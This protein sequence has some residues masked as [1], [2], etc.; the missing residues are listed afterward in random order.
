MHIFSSL[1]SGN[2]LSQTE[3]T[4]PASHVLER[5]LRVLV[6]SRLPMSPHR[7]RAKCLPALEKPHRFTCSAGWR[8]PST[9]AMSRPFARTDVLVASRTA[10]NKNS[11][12]SYDDCQSALDKNS[13][14]HL[15]HECMC[16]SPTL[17]RHV[18]RT[19]LR[20]H[21]NIHAHAQGCT[22]CQ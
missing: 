21:V 4:S 9:P 17:E 2:Q 16:P 14:D 6:S 20:T 5:S 1:E 13:N 10:L 11:S 3:R 15:P 22:P 19:Q 7:K 12:L 8:M 18:Q